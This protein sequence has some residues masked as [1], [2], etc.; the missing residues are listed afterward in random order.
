MTGWLM[1][2]GSIVFN[3]LGNLMVKTFSASTEIR[4]VGDY[5]S[6]PFVLGITAF[7]LGVVLYG[8]ALRDI[9]IVFAYPIQVGA[10]ILIISLVAVAQFNEKLGVQTMLGIV[11]VTAGVAVLSRAAEG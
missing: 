11:L 9:P 4:G 8:R 1:L 7:A 2:V 3:A 10:C 6:L 5:L